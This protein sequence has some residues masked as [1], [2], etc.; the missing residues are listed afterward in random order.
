MGNKIRIKR[1]VLFSINRSR[2]VFPFP[3]RVLL[4]PSLPPPTPTNT[5]TTTNGF[6]W[7]T[8]TT[9]MSHHAHHGN[10]FCQCNSRTFCTI[11]PRHN[12]YSHKDEARYVP[13]PVESAR[14][15]MLLWEGQQMYVGGPPQRV[16]CRR[17]VI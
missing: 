11:R 5:T 8:T 4:L 1:M 16:E 17:G 13:P 12:Y 14:R 2:R 15:I 6:S 9:T 10:C 7:R 3:R